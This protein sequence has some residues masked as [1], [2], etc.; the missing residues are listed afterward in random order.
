MTAEEYRQLE[1]RKRLEMLI[2]ESGSLQ[3]KSSAR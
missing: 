2:E 1:N 3:K